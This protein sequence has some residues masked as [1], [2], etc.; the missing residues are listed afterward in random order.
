MATEMIRSGW[1]NFICCKPSRSQSHSF[2][3]LHH[4]PLQYSFTHHPQL[5]QF[6]SKT[7]CSSHSY[8]HPHSQPGPISSLPL[9]L[10]LRSSVHGKFCQKPSTIAHSLS[11]DSASVVDFGAEPVRAGQSF[12][13]KF[14]FRKQQAMYQMT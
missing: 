1:L 4:H 5:L 9:A 3:H 11:N 10:K 13:V 2:N 6:P 7:N 12:A 14:D 8:P